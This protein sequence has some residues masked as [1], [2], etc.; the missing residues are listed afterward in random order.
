MIF[1]RRTL[2]G[3]KFIAF[4]VANDDIKQIRLHF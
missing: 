1:K 2:K 3:C 4:I